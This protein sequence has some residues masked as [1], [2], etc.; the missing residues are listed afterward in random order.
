MILPRSG[1]DVVVLGQA[2]TAG[3]VV[4]LGQALTAGVVDDQSMDGLVLLW[5]LV[6]GALGHDVPVLAELEL[7]L[8][9]FHPFHVPTAAGRSSSHVLPQLPDVLPHAAVDKGRLTKTKAE[10]IH[11]RSFLRCCIMVVSSAMYGTTDC[12]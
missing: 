6:V 5:K 10:S 3:D 12:C 9:P 2:L 4:V 8:P 1:E 7:L 11:C